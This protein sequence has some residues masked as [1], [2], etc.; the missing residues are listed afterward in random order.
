MPQQ[1]LGYIN[2]ERYLA[3]IVPTFPG[4][5]K[6]LLMGVSAGGFGA[7]L[8]Y[9]QTAKAFGSVPVYEL[10][11]SGPPMEDPYLPSC[12][13]GANATLWGFDKT[14]LKECGAD[15]PD[16]SNYGLD[17]SLHLAK[18]YP[19]VPFG[20]IDSVDD[21][22]ISEF[23]GFG[24][25]NCA[26]VTIPMPVSAATYLAGLLDAR[27]KAAA[28]P[29][30]GSFLFPGSDHTTL[31]SATYDTRTANLPGD[32]GTELLTTW[33]STLVNSGTVTNVGP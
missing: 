24:A 15:C 28:Y 6:V 19:A 8:N 20:V 3:R 7:G 10:D 32:A 4:L 26:P 2:V 22:V 13:Q 29:N 16:S 27:M 31:A 17:W 33:V 5:T 9:A 21:S 18:T 14:I 25:N 12:L 11:D 30:V 1:F 23:Y